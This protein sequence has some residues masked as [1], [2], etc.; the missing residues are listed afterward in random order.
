MKKA[1]YIYFYRIW[2][3]FEHFNKAFLN[4]KNMQM[5][6]CCVIDLYGWRK[7]ALHE[8]TPV[9]LGTLSLSPYST[10]YPWV[11]LLAHLSWKSF[12]ITSCTNVHLSLSSSC[13][14][15]FHTTFRTRP[16]LAWLTHCHSM[17]ILVRLRKYSANWYSA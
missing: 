6:F 9:S 12:L 16:T 14:R 4:A 5:V 1:W 13:N 17:H 15:R 10:I 11:F 7:D 3:L 2:F 8:I